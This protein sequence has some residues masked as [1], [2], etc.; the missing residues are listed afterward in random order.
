MPSRRDFGSGGEYRQMN[1]TVGRPSTSA[2]RP[3][4]PGRM[5]SF[6]FKPKFNIGPS[7]S[8]RQR[9]GMYLKSKGKV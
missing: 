9:M 2:V 5:G 7:Q 3:Q 4:A 6:G 8:A 1:T